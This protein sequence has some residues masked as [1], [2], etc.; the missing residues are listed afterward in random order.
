[1][2]K[3]VDK[4]L[5]IIDEAQEKAENFLKKEVWHLYLIS[6]H[7]STNWRWIYRIGGGLVE[8]SG[9]GG[10]PHFSIIYN[11]ELFNLTVL[12]RCY[13][14]WVS[15]YFI[16]RVFIVSNIYCVDKYKNLTATQ[17]REPFGSVMSK[18]GIKEEC[19]SYNSPKKPNS[20]QAS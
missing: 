14:I 3:L 1:M 10:L 20:F 8:D 12:L 5:Q 6:P 18:N 13:A 15:F 16:F 19:Y 9:G 17:I 2:G 4:Q 11:E 7:F